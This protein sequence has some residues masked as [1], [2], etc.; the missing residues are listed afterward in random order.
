MN[1]A[2]HNNASYLVC[3]LYKFVTLENYKQ[4][5]EPLREFMEQH[6]I[7]GTILLAQEGLNGTVSGPQTSIDLLIERL[8]ADLRIAPISHKFSWHQEQ[9]FYRTK[10]KLKKEIVTMGVSG[11]DPLKTVG[12]YVDPKDWNALISDPEVTVIDTRNDYEIEIGTFKN[13]IN[14]QTESFR[15][16]PQYVSEQLDP[17]KHKK[18][19]M[20]CTGG[21]RCEKSTA[22]LKEQ[23]FDQVYHLRG[24]ILQYL[25]DVP[26]SQSLWEGDCFVFDNRVA[27]NHQLEKSH[28]DQCYGC[29]LP[30]TQQDKQSE[31]YEAG[32]TCPSC[33]GRHSEDQLARFRE[34]E[35]QVTLAK[36][37]AQEHVGAQARDLMQSKRI[38]KAQAQSARALAR[39]KQAQSQ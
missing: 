13:A 20:Y 28:Y 38:E 7:R 33:F 21:I 19:A 10:V 9:P 26:A 5:R 29:R 36:Q 16:F 17:A 34:R 15:E 11:I 31:Q 37:R 22:Y 18:V 12:T 27:V 25:E 24:G 35:K 3:A 23:G 39:N 8:N 32:V 1:T 30:I 4:M 14:P 2:N 6:S